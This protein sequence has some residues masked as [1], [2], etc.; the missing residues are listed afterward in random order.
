MKGK[1]MTGKIDYQ[2]LANADISESIGNLN[3][4]DHLKG[5]SIDELRDMCNMD[6]LPF[7][8]CVLNITGELNVG[9]IVRN[10]LLT[11]A[12]KVGIIGRRKYDKRGTVGSYNYLEVDRV[13]GLNED[14]I[15]IDPAVFW[16]WM[17]QNRFFPVF[18]E[19]GGMLL[20]DVD[21]DDV[22]AL[23]MPYQPCLVFGNENR[24]VQDDLLNDPR[25]TVV[26][27]EQRGVIRS[28]NVA[29]AAAIVMYNLSGYMI[30]SDES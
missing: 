9:T 7:G 27:I 12:S 4:H 30:R 5:R 26:S 3:V 14:G 1:I 24:G 19:H 23:H 10:A 29:S 25:G 16:G 11:G 17:E 18:I 6:R 15:T 20:D 8:A 13:D 2:E 21:W 22:E 28:F